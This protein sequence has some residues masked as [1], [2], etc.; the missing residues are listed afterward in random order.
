[1]PE[2]GLET[3]EVKDQLDEARERA[4]EA[5][6]GESRGGTGWLTW[7]SL[8]TAF[9]A[10]LAAVASLHAGALANE[11]L[12]R[13]SDAVL[14]ESEYADNWSEYQARTMKSYLFE[15]E[16]ALL[17]DDARK[18]AQEHAQHERE[19]AD[20]LKPTAQRLRKK[21]DENNEASMQ[22]IERHELFAKTVTIFQISIAVAAIA[23][24]TRKKPMWWLSL[25]GG[26]AGI[27]LLGLAFLAS[28]GDKAAAEPGPSHASPS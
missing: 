3:Q 26:A 22:R 20:K 28:T 15:T 19:E 11:A 6:E 8:S 9:L 14:A 4:G 5:Q 24:L 2:E 17:A 10:A 23:A 16:A 7:L 21:V 1:M 13:K 27:A 25:L 18:S 12:L